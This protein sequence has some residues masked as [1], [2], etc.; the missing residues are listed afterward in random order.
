MKHKT[1]T[2][3]VTGIG[4][5]VGQGILRNIIAL[6]YPIRL[7]GTNTI[8]VSAGNHLCDK[9]YKVPDADGPEYEDTVV[10]ICNKESV[11]L[12]IPST[13]AETYYLAKIKE[14]IPILSSSQENVA[15]IFYDKYETFLKFHSYNIPFAQS[16]LPSKYAGGY[17]HVIVKPRTGRGSRGIHV[18]PEVLSVFDDTYVAQHLYTGIEITT[19]FYVTRSR[20]VLGHITFMRELSHGFTALC[21]V[22]DKY[23]NKINCIIDAIVRNFDI[24]GSFNIQSIVEHKTG[25]IVPFE[26][27]GRISGTNSI[28][29]QF[30]FE[31]VRYTIEENLYG[32]KLS[33]PAIRY[34]SA[35]RLVVD[36]IYPGISLKD[37]KNNKDTY[38]LN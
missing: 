30:G 36:I 8:A 14:H 2:V 34:G 11:D 26:I 32:K 7:I 31:D 1:K 27:N 19:S 25:N 4:G 17:P 6:E 20:K 12:I 16:S 23:D 10:K 15:Y 29:S 33:K 38:Y 35:L 3:M 18:N 5:N 37:I 24:K 13:D 21:E 28:R 22:T 9:V